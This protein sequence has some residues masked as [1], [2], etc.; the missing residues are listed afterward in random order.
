MLAHHPS[1]KTRY[2]KSSS[3][4]GSLNADAASRLHR[5]SSGALALSAGRATFLRPKASGGA[6]THVNAL[7]EGAAG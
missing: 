5:A 7:P 4:A 2:V 1:T 3:A 6:L